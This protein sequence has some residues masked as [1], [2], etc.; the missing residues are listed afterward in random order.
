MVGG[1]LKCLGPS[2]RLRSRYGHGYQI[3]VSFCIPD[4]QVVGNLVATIIS[5]SQT[6]VP[7]TASAGMP[8][9]PVMSGESESEIMISKAKLLSAFASNGK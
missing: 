8:S 4:E 2:Q 6:T 3:E 7:E 5:S 9:V 1:K